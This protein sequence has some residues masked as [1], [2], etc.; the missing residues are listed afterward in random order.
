MRQVRT[1]DFCGADATG[2][3]EPLPPDLAPNSPRLLLCEACRDRLASVVDPLLDRLDADRLTPTDDATGDATDDATG[4]AETRDGTEPDLRTPTSTDE[5]P[6]IGPD[7]GTD[8]NRASDAGTDP[9]PDAG[10]DTNPVSEQE[11]G[12]RPV[13]QRKGTPRGYRKVMRFLENRE[14]PLD[15]A[16]AEQLAADAYGLDPETVSAAVD[17]AVKYDRLSDVGGELRR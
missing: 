16:E 1:C 3:Y 7:A 4:D 12:G 11:A 2:V 14:F 13:N 8:A 5:S 10:V 9:T 15:R 17:H 6:E